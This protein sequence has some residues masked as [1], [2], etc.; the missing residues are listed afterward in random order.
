MKGTKLKGVKAVGYVK[1][2]VKEPIK[3]EKGKIISYKESNDEVA[4]IM[5]KRLDVETFAEFVRDH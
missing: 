1:R 4:Y 5:D 3:D 2:N